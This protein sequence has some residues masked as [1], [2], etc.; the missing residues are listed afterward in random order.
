MER[1]LLVD[2]Y[3]I[4]TTIPSVIISFI[5]VGLSTGFIPAYNRIESDKGTQ[6]ANC[7]MN[8]LILFLFVIFSFIIA[9]VFFNTDIVVDIF[10][11]GFNAD[12]KELAVNMT[13]IAIVSIYFIGILH[14]FIGFLNI[15]G[16]YNIPVLMGIPLN[17]VIILSI[18]ISNSTNVYVIS[19]GTVIANFMQFLVLYI[20]SKRKGFKMYITYKVWDRNIKELVVI[21]IPIIL[22]VSLSQINSIVD[23]TLA[24]SISVG[25]ISR[26]KLMLIN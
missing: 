23:R 5:G 26:F 7:F 4:S 24:S 8:K 12:T 3:L 21:S 20:F 25:G 9:I 22:G 11:K 14:L 17:I 6:S 2:A 19:I 18:I 13:R 16:S 15:R 1:L 10:A